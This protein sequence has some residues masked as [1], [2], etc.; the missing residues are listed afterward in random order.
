MINHHASSAFWHSQSSRFAIAWHTLTV[1]FEVDFRNKNQL[2]PKA[3]DLVSS[4]VYAC[5]QVWPPKR[6]QQ[7]A[8]RPLAHQRKGKLA[9]AKRHW[10]PPS[11]P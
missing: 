6:I 8:A 2:P 9:S 11:P 4:S 5:S 3:E 7:L 10:R 1:R